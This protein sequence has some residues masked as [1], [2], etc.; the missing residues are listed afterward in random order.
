MSITVTVYVSLIS[1]VSKTLH[2]VLCYFIA[3][4]NEMKK[5]MEQQV[6]IAFSVYD[7]RSF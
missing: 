5:E 2:S 7:H 1:T 4:V 6:L 3:E